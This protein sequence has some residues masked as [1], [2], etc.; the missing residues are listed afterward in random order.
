M[1]VQTYIL[2]LSLLTQKITHDFCSVLSSLSNLCSFIG[3]FLVL[4]HSSVD[5]PVFIE[6]VPLQKVMCLFLNFG[7][8]NNPAVK[9]LLQTSFCKCVDI[10]LYK[11]PEGGKFQNIDGIIMD[12]IIRDNV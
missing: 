5:V 7:F 9:H 2:T 11:F 1:R 3:V 12:G 4:F 8:A 10:F 6:P